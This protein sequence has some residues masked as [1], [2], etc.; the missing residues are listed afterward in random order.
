MC[1]QNVILGSIDF[2]QMSEVCKHCGA[3]FWYEERAEKSKKLKS[4]YFSMC[5]MKAKIIIPY[6]LDPPELLLNLLS[7][8]DSRSQHFVENIRAYNNIFAFSYIGGKIDDTL[9]DGGD[10]PQFV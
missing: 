5:F 8:T 1:F 3:T 7:S 4:P 9:N 10:P 2:G 6:L